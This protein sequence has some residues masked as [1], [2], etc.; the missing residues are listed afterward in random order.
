MAQESLGTL[1]F[2]SILNGED[3]DAA[4]QYLK[5]FVKI[6]RRERMEAFLENEERICHTDDESDEDEEDG[7][8]NLEIES[9]PTKKSK[10]DS[11]KQD[12]KGYNVPF[13]GTS[14]QKG[15]T[16]KV[17]KGT[18]PTG[19]LEVY[20]KASPNAIEIIGNDAFLP[21]NGSFHRNLLR[22]KDKVGKRKSMN[23]HNIYIQAVGEIATSSIPIQKLK[24]LSSVVSGDADGV[25]QK[26]A[27]MIIKD[28]LRHLLTVLNN[29]SSS[30]ASQ[31]I[32]ES[33]FVTLKYLAISSV[34][35]AREIAGEMDT[36]VKDGVLQK[37]AFYGTRTKEVLSKPDEHHD[38]TNDPSHEN[39]IKKMIISFKVQN[40]FL[41]F[42][43]VM[44]TYNDATILSYVTNPG[45]RENRTKP[46]IAYLSLHCALSYAKKLK[47]EV[48]VSNSIL[49]AGH[50]SLGRLL[51]SIRVHLLDAN[52]GD[53]DQ[54]SRL[55]LSNNALVDFFQD[56]ILEKIIQLSVLAGLRD[57]HSLLKDECDHIIQIAL[58]DHLKSPFLVYLKFDRSAG[59]NLSTKVSTQ[60]DKAIQ[61][62]LTVNGD[63]KS[64][65]FIVKCFNQTPS[66]FHSWMK[67]QPIP[68]P[69]PSFAFLS[70]ISLLSLMLENGPIP[71]QDDSKE[72]QMDTNG[73]IANII[74]KSLSKNILTKTL[75]SNN[76]LLVSSSMKL[77]I[78]I[79]LR[80]QCVIKFYKIGEDEMKVLVQKINGRLPDL[81][82]LLAL[83]SR[84]DPFSKNSLRNTVSSHE[85]VTL[86]LCEIIE[87]YSEFFPALVRD[88]QYDWIKFLP[89]FTSFLQV[90]R[91]VQYRI[92]KCLFS[93]FQCLRSSCCNTMIGSKFVRSLIN[94]MLRTED[95]T[96]YDLS[97]NLIESVMSNASFSGMGI[98]KDEIDIWIDA[99][100]EDTVDS[101]CDIFE[102]AQK[103]H[104]QIETII[105]SAKKDL[106]SNGDKEDISISPLLVI[107]LLSL[108]NEES[109][110]PEV[111]RFLCRVITKL[112]LVSS[113]C[114]SIVAVIEYIFNGSNLSR[115]SHVELKS[116]LQYSYSNAQS[117]NIAELTNLCQSTFG[118]HHFHAIVSEIV[119]SEQKTSKKAFN[120]LNKI[121]SETPSI[122]I[123]VYR[124]CELLDNHFRLNKKSEQVDNVL[125]YV[126]PFSL[127]EMGK[128]KMWGK[129][130]Y[131]TVTFMQ[132]LS[133]F[134]IAYAHMASYS[135][136]ICADH[137]IHIEAI[138]RALVKNKDIIRSKNKYL[139]QACIVQFIP[140]SLR[141]FWMESLLAI[142]QNNESSFQ[143]LDIGI[144][145]KSLKLFRAEQFKTHTIEK[146]CFIWSELL[147]QVEKRNL[148]PIELKLLRELE[149]KLSESINI[150]S[151]NLH[152]L[153]VIFDLNPKRFTKIIN[154]DLDC[155]A[156]TII[157]NDVALIGEGVAEYVLKES[158]MSSSARFSI[159]SN[160]I[161]E[162]SAQ[163]QI[164]MQNCD[165]Y[166]HLL[167]FIANGL[168]KIVNHLNKEN[169]IEYGIPRTMI[170]ALDA[171]WATI[172]QH[173]EIRQRVLES[174]TITLE[175]SM[176]LKRRDVDKLLETA[177]IS[178]LLH[179]FT[180]NSFRTGLERLQGVTMQYMIK[181][182]PRILKEKE[183][184][185]LRHMKQIITIL[186]NNIQTP[187]HQLDKLL[188]IC[189]KL[190]ITDV[191]D[192]QSCFCIKVAKHIVSVS[193]VIEETDNLNVFSPAQVHDMILTHS[194]FKYVMENDSS[195]RKELIDLMVCCVSLS[196]GLISIPENDKID[197]LLLNYRGSVR[198]VDRLLRLLLH[199]YKCQQNIK[200]F[201]HS[202]KWGPNQTTKF[203]M[204]N[205]D[206][207][208]TDHFQHFEWFAE[209]LDVQRVRKTISDFPLYD[210]LE[211]SPL[212][213]NNSF[214]AKSNENNAAENM[215]LNTQD[216]DSSSFYS[217]S[218]E[219]DDDFSDAGKATVIDSTWEASD[220]DDRYSP[221]AIIPYI[222]AILDA[223][224]NV[225]FDD[226][227]PL[228]PALQPEYDADEPT[229]DMNKLKRETFVR[230]AYRLFQKG[231]ISL[232]LSCLA[233]KCSGIRKLSVAILGKFLK[234]L[235]MEESQTIS[236]WKSRPQIEMTLDAIQRGLMI[237]RARKM[238]DA[239]ASSEQGFVPLI[240]NI[241]ALFL[242]RALIVLN[243]PGD[244]MYP[245]INKY[246]LRVDD[247]HGAYNDCFSLP[248]FMALFCSVNES[249][250]SI[251]RKE[252][253]FAVQLLKDGTIDE[254]CYKVASKRHIPELLLT[255]LSSFLSKSDFSDEYECL[256]ILGSMEKL[257][258]NGGSVAY[259]HYFKSVG[260][261]AW[262][263]NTIQSCITN[264][265]FR[266]HT[267]LNTLVRLLRII[268]EKYQSF[269]EKENDD[270]LFL[271]KL[272]SVGIL[273]L[274][275]NF[276][277]AHASS[278]KI[279]STRNAFSA[280]EEIVKIICS[281]HDIEMIYQKGQ[282]H[283]YPFPMIQ[284][285]GFQVQMALALLESKE[286]DIEDGS[287]NKIITVFSKFP[288][289]AD[290]SNLEDRNRV[291][292]LCKSC[293]KSISKSCTDGI[294]TLDVPILVLQR[295][296]LLGPMISAT[297][298]CYSILLDDLL[299]FR[300]HAI[301]EH[302][303]RKIWMDCLWNMVKSLDAN[304]EMSRKYL[305][306]MDL[307]DRLERDAVSKAILN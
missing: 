83:R 244:D 104:I 116:L 208:G 143:M 203:P 261:L 49:D 130:D 220:D 108:S 165:W 132:H 219:V 158:E 196:K 277:R 267:L 180:R 34:G 128:N 140:S 77:I 123:D 142:K 156:I 281:V 127:Q 88:L 247:H 294:D 222:L 193:S 270:D 184:C 129:Y 183:L 60:L 191:G 90:S 96:V 241:S 33:V 271:M 51:A 213:W 197:L 295:I 243:K 15:P 288:I 93:I 107:S 92:L 291:V 82:I 204:D 9:R 201:M 242:S 151:V 29:E 230:V 231:A 85:I 44:L 137:G 269:L 149:I 306:L 303:L 147:A 8:E 172:E 43:S 297:D 280:S 181:N 97:R 10:I 246:F 253:C 126:L 7:D 136:F 278:K 268:L 161:C 287:M 233:S 164:Y 221:G 95:K 53:K 276:H 39:A 185:N 168:T 73:I 266:T 169:Q 284:S 148:I 94:I 102:T 152:I 2:C 99:M 188:A 224:E 131:S 89:D 256:L 304:T 218:D 141:S 78:D 258:I 65:Q 4:Y 100:L 170:N 81:Q 301:K 67:H 255:T 192:Y 154:Y 103:A 48:S 279:N 162:I 3:A 114:E 254:L 182:L 166:F 177:Y 263:Q 157:K 146:L 57:R 160:I 119:R 212:M 109:V 175:N 173:Q 134:I 234:A 225:E 76:S 202:L 14:F 194:K 106:W 5:R 68:D 145:C 176:T 80:Y 55:S 232:V 71:D 207:L 122:S 189:L 120:T 163:R 251:A 155:I 240:P 56:G 101:F 228:V 286:I 13:V 200:P 216:S 64:R 32:L 37:L 115:V 210:T 69:K 24:S 112:L 236:N 22:R 125:F 245:A 105:Q 63:M 259:R 86:H 72:N 195:T 27:S 36:H 273:Q 11:W 150:P 16:G 19:F 199:S 118:R 264:E 209:C 40:A 282:N 52:V 257:I 217:S 79:F 285:C 25:D 91:C 23:L 249:D 167:K 153:N 198:N 1:E 290:F 38:K 283:L 21:P 45:G 70:I 238:Q 138:T 227:S 58:S 75:Q 250:E 46:G 18:W 12:T 239:D 292:D 190:G 206:L 300:S 35:I 84:F 211:P 178:L 223:F 74:P 260:L 144:L 133:L 121:V 139:V 41:D 187:N 298:I 26:I 59:R 296:S 30:G 262:I 275:G 66:L 305:E 42:A 6:C 226:S 214:C 293:V 235:K 215:S 62:F 61:E 135:E 272:D 205:F 274:L 113:N 98:K 307:L 117:T 299:A 87:M 229:I 289:A 111:V 302:S 186:V 47:D 171:A 179:V 50:A 174:L 124:Q 159:A 110:G 265:Y 28:F 17:I 237:A 54:L 252:R 248:A 20:L 31:P